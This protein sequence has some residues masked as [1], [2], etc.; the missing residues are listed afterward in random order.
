MTGALAIFA[1]TSSLSPVKTRLAVDIGTTRAEKFY[2]LSVAAV[3]EIVKVSQKQNNNAF[4]PYWALAEKDA[5]TYKQWQGFDK[6]WT[7]EGGFG[8]RLHNIYSTLCQKHD[9]VILIG[10]D[11]PQLEPALFSDVIK[12]LSEQARSCI[13]GPATDGGFYLFAMKVA[14]AESLWMNVEY[15]QATTLEKLSSNLIRQGI[16]IQLLSPQGDVDTINDFKPLIRALEANNNLLPTQRK[17]Y[18]W[19]QSQM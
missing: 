6:I 5:V 13:I 4:V 9:Y 14:M 17:L 15:S 11:S 19:L 2:E 3:E 12:K 7:G 1:K 8:A 16:D 10:T 18:R